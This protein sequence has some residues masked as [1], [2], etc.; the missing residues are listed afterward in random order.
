M[1]D[2]PSILTPGA[3]LLRVGHCDLQVPILTQWDVSKGSVFCFDTHV[4]PPADREAGTAARDGSES[5][6]MLL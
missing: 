3:L 2:F 4:C 6:Q 5:R 1:T